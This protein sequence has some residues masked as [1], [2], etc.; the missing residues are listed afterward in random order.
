L[1]YISSQGVFVFD[2]E[3]GDLLASLFDHNDWGREITW[4]PD[5]TMLATTASDNTLR[6]YTIGG[7]E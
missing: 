6:V 3:S 7:G 1:A 4:S 5:Q 2:V